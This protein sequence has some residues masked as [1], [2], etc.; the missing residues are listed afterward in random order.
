MIDKETRELSAE[1]ASEELVITTG[2]VH[3][4][5]GKCILK[6]HVRNGVV[7][8]ITSDEGEEPQLR[9][10]LKGRAY[11][12]RIYHPDRLKYP[13]K[14]VG[15]RGTSS[16]EKVSWDEA[17][18]TVARELA[19]I[20]RTYGPEAILA[21]GG[22]GNMTLL[23]NTGS[24]VLHR[25]LNMFGGGTVF[26]GSMS[27]GAAH[28]ASR[29]TLGSILAGNDPEDLLHSHLIILWAWN[30]AEATMGSTTNFY[31]TQA[32]ESGTKVICIDPRLTETVAAWADQWIPI[33][34]GTD[35]AMMVAMAHVMVV[36]Q[37]Q[38]QAF[39][40]SYTLGFDQF[41]GYVLGISDGLPKTPAWA[42]AITGV[43]RAIIE[44]VAREYA[45]TKPA[46]LLPGW[47]MQRTA[48]GEQSF[49]AS[50][51]LAAMTG[52]I[53]ISGGNAAGNYAQEPSYHHTFG[54]FDP[55]PNP[56]GKS[57]PVNKWADALLLG[58]AGGY[59]S[60]IKMLYSVGRNLLNQVPSINKG[61]EA[62]KKLEFIVVHEQFMT[63]TA[64]FADILLPV[65][66]WFERE[67]LCLTNK[68]AIYM[69]RVIEP[70]YECKSDLEIFS[71]LSRRLGIPGYNDKEGEE[72]LRSFVPDSEI[73]DFAEFKR[74]GVWHFRRE[75]LYVAFEQ[76]I[77]D[78]AHNPFPTPSGKIEIYSQRLADLK[79]P[80]VIPPIPKYIE[81]WE[82]RRDSLV[83]RFPLLLITPPRQTIHPLHYDQPPLAAG[84][85]T[86][87]SLDQ[88]RGC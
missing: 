32:K 62:L 76:Q 66:T 9:A 13:L 80:E 29:Y 45:T 20:K 53:G 41:R 10:C 58:K 71:E 63:P 73:P 67:D 78:P 52:N 86:P 44:Q 19:R 79:Q 23:H 46:A 56:V 16:F 15:E 5:G 72:W 49:R 39:L 65:T 37:L 50:I 24:G 4:C 6:A 48:Y 30:S 87:S 12:Q 31:L 68:Y 17:L 11:R 77:R 8:H 43:P 83:A 70:L 14:R 36:E 47:A 55:G 26:R 2:C 35:A 88:P 59:E 34:P 69:N 81:G 75:R 61:V 28:A 84:S 3:D 21:G 54:R 42:E 27:F 64:K 25:F 33:Y 85:R 51:T 40:D 60:D 57:I 18:D 38:D 7:A 22:P 74:K 1:P 82:G